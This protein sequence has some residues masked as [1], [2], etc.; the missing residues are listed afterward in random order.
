MLLQDAAT[1][2]FLRGSTGQPSPLLPAMTWRLCFSNNAS[3]RVDLTAPP[4]GYNRSLYQGYVDDV[5]AGRMESVWAAWSGPRPLP[6]HGDKFDINCN[7][8]PLGFVW[9]G[10]QKERLINATG[11]ARVQLVEELRNITIG[12]LWF[13]RTSPAG[14]P[15]NECRLLAANSSDTIPSS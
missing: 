13:Q 2:T 15:A 9:A 14:C 10:P 7:P 1:H 8:R 12:L 6:P 11:P 3:N 5:S 4:H